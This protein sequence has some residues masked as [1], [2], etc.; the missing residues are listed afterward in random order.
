MSQP[1]DYTGPGAL[2]GGHLGAVC[3]FR[4]FADVLLE[5]SC[6]GA[7]A[8]SLA[9][10]EEYD[11][12]TA[13]GSKE[14]VEAS[15]SRRKQKPSYDMCRRVWTLHNNLGHAEMHNVSQQIAN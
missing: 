9:D 6:G 14:A 5:E 10:P 13:N 1:G 4:D 8:G 11:D 7:Y 15:L 3:H 12:P 2:L